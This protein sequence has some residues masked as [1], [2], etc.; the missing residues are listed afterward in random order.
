MLEWK[1]AETEGK[2]ADARTAEAQLKMGE[3]KQAAKV[4]VKAVIKHDDL[5]LKTVTKDTM[6]VRG[7]TGTLQRVRRGDGEGEGFDTEVLFEG[8]RTE[9]EKM[10][11]VLKQTKKNKAT[12]EEENFASFPS[13]VIVKTGDDHRARDNGHDS[14]SGG[15]DGEF[16]FEPDDVSEMT[17]D[18]EGSGLQ[19]SFRAALMKRDQH[20][21][22]LCE[23]PGF[24]E[25]AHIYPKKGD[26]TIPFDSTGFTNRYCT[27]NGILLCKRCHRFFDRGYWWIE[28]KDNKYVAHIFEALRS[29]DNFEERHLHELLIDSKGKEAPDVDL[30]KVQK[31]FCHERRIARHN[32]LEAKQF[33]CDVCCTTEMR[34]TNE[35]SLCK[36][37]ER[38]S[39]LPPDT[40]LLF[41]PSKS[42]PSQENR[43]EQGGLE[44]EDANDD[45]IGKQGGL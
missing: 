9:V 18:T 37:I 30:L 35:A 36:H 38:N 17:G 10:K 27:Q 39:C 5:G 34:W 41:S 25:A 31:E 6:K 11:K 3:R 24:L 22:A 33:G 28:L 26:R 8:L 42:K 32:L 14:S 7:L 20:Q 44:L 43:A 2:K 19:K 40:P 15:G 13:I 29:F 23:S 12:F 1:K 4:M 21:C 16:E 45:V